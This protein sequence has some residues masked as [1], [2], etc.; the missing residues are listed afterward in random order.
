[1]T[2]VL[3]TGAARGIG[4]ALAEGFLADGFTVV[5]A[6]RSEA[7][8]AEVAAAGAVPVVADMADPAQVE[9]MVEAAAA[10]TGRLD[11]LVNNAGVGV[12]VPVAEHQAG[13]FEHVLAVN[14]FGPFHAMRV[15]I[16]LMQAQGHGRIINVV[17]RHAEGKM[18]GFAAYGSSK[19]ALWAVSGSAA[20]ECRGTGVLVNCLIPGP[21]RTAMNPNG[22]QEPDVVYP[23]AKMLATLPDDGPT[24]KV[25]WEEEEYLLFQP[26]KRRES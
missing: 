4:R 9:A 14:L 18:A 3:V 24:G 5:A 7:A 23:T 20:R 17:S 19:A 26:V 1:M 16:P 8:L 11:V 10:V 25:F 6:D 2:T 12:N 13:Q 21:T 15:A 22:T